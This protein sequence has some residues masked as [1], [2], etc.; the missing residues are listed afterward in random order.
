MAL[1][2]VALGL[3]LAGCGLERGAEVTF[4][5]HPGPVWRDG[6]G[7]AVSAEV[8]NVIRGP[9][10]CGWESA[11]ILHVGWPLGTESQDASQSRQYVRDPHGVLRDVAPEPPDLDVALLED[12]EPTGY[13][14]RGLELWINPEE[15]DEELYLVTGAGAERWSR[16]DEFACE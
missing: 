7:D 14:T 2:P 10:H 15:L 11:A 8:L 4:V 9:E 3:V 1:P 12:A 5:D 6:E 16:A 13:V